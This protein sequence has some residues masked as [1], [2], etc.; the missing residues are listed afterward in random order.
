[1]RLIGLTGYAGSGK[2]TV[3]AILEKQHGAR[4]LAFADPIREMLRPLLRMLGAEEHMDIRALKEQTLAG[5]KVS[6][7]EL[8]QTLGTEW[9]CEKLD[10]EFWVKIAAARVDGAWYRPAQLVV[11]SDVRFPNETDWIT[12][13]G[14]QIWHVDRPALAAV[15]SHV[16]EQ[17][18]RDLPVHLRIDNRGT[19]DDLASE[20]RR[21]VVMDRHLT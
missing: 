18:V 14:G 6:Y 21:A 19:L 13:R 12:Y 17:W 2:D 20:V 9:A 11:I 10:P 8:A 3:R 15:R 5:L 1:M 16:S 7:R 4:G